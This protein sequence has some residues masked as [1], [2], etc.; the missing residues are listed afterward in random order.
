MVF[1]YPVMNSDMLRVEEMINSN[2]FDCFELHTLT[3]KNS[4]YF[5]LQYLYQKYNFKDQMLI[6]P[7][8][9]QKFA[10]KL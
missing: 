5:M 6:N 3:K 2:D 7:V 4:L 9:F 8:K 1:D 10:L